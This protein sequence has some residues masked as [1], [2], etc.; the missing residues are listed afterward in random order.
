MVERASILDSPSFDVPPSKFSDKQDKPFELQR[1]LNL[2]RLLEQR[3][4]STHGDAYIINV[5]DAI[6][7]G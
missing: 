5:I 6:R 1:A 3:L 7:Y 4:N 2:F